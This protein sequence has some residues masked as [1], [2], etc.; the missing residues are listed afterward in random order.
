MTAAGTRH[1]AE[2]VLAVAVTAVAAESVLAV[3]VTAVAAESVIAVAV[4]AVAVDSV[5]ALVVT[6]V[7]AE[8]VFA[9]AETVVAAA[10]KAVWLK[11]AEALTARAAAVPTAAPSS[12]PTTTINM[13]AMTPPALATMQPASA[14]LRK[15]QMTAAGTLRAAKRG[16]AVAVTVV[17][18]AIKPV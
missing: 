10:I 5:L 18:A 14:R 3:A 7:A 1:A 4:T 6:A 16:F 17:A 15:L 8:R 12:I 9:V 13:R 11:R 2:R